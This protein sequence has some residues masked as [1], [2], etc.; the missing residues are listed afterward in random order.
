MIQYISTVRSWKVMTLHHMCYVSASRFAKKA[1]TFFTPNVLSLE[2]I[3]W[4]EHPL[5]VPLPTLLQRNLPRISKWEV[6]IE[7]LK[8]V[9]LGPD[10]M[11]PHDDYFCGHLRRAILCWLSINNLRWINCLIDD[12]QTIRAA[13]KYLGMMNSHETLRFARIFH[14][15]HPSEKVDRAYRINERERRCS[16]YTFKLS[17]LKVV[18][19]VMEHAEGFPRFYRAIRLVGKLNFRR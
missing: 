18:R 17:A 8:Y 16:D 13:C 10:D 11:D 9:E 3:D 12:S 14:F 2:L 15:G 1:C 6:E 19:A 5:P 4:L 7:V